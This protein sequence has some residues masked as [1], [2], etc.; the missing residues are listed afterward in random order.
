MQNHTSMYTY[1]YIYISLQ[2][3][4]LLFCDLI[5]SAFLSPLSVHQFVLVFWIEF[6]LLHLYSETFW[7]KRISRV[8]AYMI[9]THI[10][11]QFFAYMCLI[12]Q[13]SL[14][15]THQ[16]FLCM[17]LIPF[18]LYCPIF[19]V[20]TS[21]ACLYLWTLASISIWWNTTHSIVPQDC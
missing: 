15:N 9:T 21:I 2:L 13:P 12:L 6:S 3:L 18:S 10:K 8:F 16:Y 7:Y 20:K 1:I 4:F 17:T 14:R 5:L 11:I 19:V